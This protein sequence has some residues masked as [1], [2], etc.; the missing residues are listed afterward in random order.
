MWLSFAQ[1]DTFLSRYQGTPEEVYSHQ[2]AATPGHKSVL[3]QRQDLIAEKWLTGLL[4]G[5][6]V[7]A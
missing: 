4:A 2:A 3:E 7:R 6:K 1:E 5:H